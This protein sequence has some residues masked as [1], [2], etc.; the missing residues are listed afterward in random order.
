[1]NDTP[2]IEDK[3]GCVVRGYA[4]IQAQLNQQLS[5]ILR[6]SAMEKSEQ[7]TTITYDEDQKLVRLFTAIRRDQGRLKRAGVLPT[8]EDKWGGMSYEVPLTR[9]KWR[10]AS[11]APSKRGFAKGRPG[12]PRTTGQTP[13]RKG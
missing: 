4:E 12:N 11:G 1:M 7:E 10:I 6:R 8:G 13:G 5:L 9:F 3:Q 2:I